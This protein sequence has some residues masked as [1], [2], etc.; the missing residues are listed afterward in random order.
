VAPTLS[1]GPANADGT[2]TLT[3]SSAPSNIE[4]SIDAVA[5]TT[6]GWSDSGPATLKLMPGSYSLDFRATRKL[7]GRFYSRQRYRPADA[8]P[9]YRGRTATNRSFDPETGTETTTTLNPFGTQIF[10]NGSGNVTLSPV[11]RWTL[12]LPL[13]ENPW[14][15]AVSSS[16]VGEFDGKELADAVLTLEFMG[17]A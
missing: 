10:K 16:D 5:G 1:A 11:D 3:V 6:R 4:V 17:S 12:E 7:S 2:V 14:F 15:L 8:V 9:L 13:Q